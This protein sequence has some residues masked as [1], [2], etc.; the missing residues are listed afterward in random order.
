[1][2][3]ADKFNFDIYIKIWSECQKRRI[4]NKIKYLKL[5]TYKLL[6][7]DYNTEIDSLL[8]GINIYLSFNNERVSGISVVILWIN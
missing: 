1:M 3:K 7:F 4:T 8:Q 2:H 6:K 5:Y